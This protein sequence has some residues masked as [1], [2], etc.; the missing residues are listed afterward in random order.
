MEETI[1]RKDQ[2]HKIFNWVKSHKTEIIVAGVSIAA[3]TALILEI[4]NK[5]AVL[6]LLKTVKSES[7]P[8]PLK[9]Q[10]LLNNNAISESCKSTRIYTAPQNPYNVDWHIRNM[11]GGRHHSPEKAAEALKLGIELLPNQTIVDSYTKGLAA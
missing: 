9:T 4:K 11:S 5:D 6:E 3:I 2:E 1:L 8:V 7:N 10:A